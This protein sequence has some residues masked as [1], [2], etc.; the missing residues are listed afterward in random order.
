MEQI[1][2]SKE[3]WGGSQTHLNVLGQRHRLLLTLQGSGPASPSAL[4]PRGLEEEELS[5]WRGG[6]WECL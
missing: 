3:Q 6:Q 5:E 2:K 1:L 4:N